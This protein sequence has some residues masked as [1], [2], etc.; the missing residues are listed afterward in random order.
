VDYGFFVPG[1]TVRVGEPNPRLMA[2]GFAVEAKEVFLRRLPGPTVGVPLAEI[3]RAPENGLCAEI[4]FSRQTP[5][6][7]IGEVPPVTV[8][9]TGVNA[10]FQGQ[11]LD[12]GNRL[13]RHRPGRWNLFH[14]VES[15]SG[16]GSE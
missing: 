12:E 5:K 2:T 10:V 9:A 4:E 14:P 1:Q 3:L 7:V 13:P 11:E 15:G 8:Y 6:G 16:P